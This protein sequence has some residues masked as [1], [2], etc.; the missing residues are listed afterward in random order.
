VRSVRK[1]TS[2]ALQIGVFSFNFRPVL[3]EMWP[4]SV[5]NGVFEL[6]IVFEP[7]TKPSTPRRRLLL[8]DGHSSHLIA[9][10]VAFCLENA[11]DLVVLPPHSSYLL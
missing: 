10:F 6:T 11:I 7:E 2:T 3:V 9:K 5:C 8:T 4:A 1:C